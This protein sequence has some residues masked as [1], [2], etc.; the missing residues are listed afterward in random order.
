MLYG[1]SSSES[2][3]TPSGKACSSCGGCGRG[4]NSSSNTCPRCGGR[5]SAPDDPD[6]PLAIAA[7]HFSTGGGLGTAE[8]NRLFLE[9]NP[10][11]EC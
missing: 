8:I 1:N 3:K 7:F 2:G 5:G 11:T 4:K 9:E 10:A 6:G